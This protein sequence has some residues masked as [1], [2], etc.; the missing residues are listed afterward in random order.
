MRCAA[1][2]LA[3]SLGGSALAA[4]PAGGGGDAAVSAWFRSLRDARG[5]SCCDE[6]D[7]RRTMIR[8]V[9]GVGLEAWIGRSEFGDGA[10]DEWREVPAREVRSRGDRP[11]GVRGA[12]VCFYAGRVACADLEDGT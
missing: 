10:P 6:A 2:V 9:D 8:P 5:V 3:V 12:I 7:C 4:P 11:A 1:A